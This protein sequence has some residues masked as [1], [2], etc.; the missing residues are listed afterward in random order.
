MAGGHDRA[1][2]GPGDGWFA[3]KRKKGYRRAGE[4]ATGLRGQVMHTATHRRP[5]ERLGALV[6]REVA[7]AGTVIKVVGLGAAMVAAQGYR[8]KARGFNRP[9]PD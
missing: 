6:C 8:T 4:C 3:Q 1:G 9:R 5:N 7:V 2:R